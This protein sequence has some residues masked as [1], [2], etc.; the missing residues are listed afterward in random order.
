MELNTIFYYLTRENKQ[1]D[2]SRVGGD[3]M[4]V[5]VDVKEN[6]MIG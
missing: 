1:S 3:M 6:I 5:E 2:V 4:W